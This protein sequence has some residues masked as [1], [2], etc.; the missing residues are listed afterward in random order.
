MHV[1]QNGLD[2]VESYVSKIRAVAVLDSMN[3]RVKVDVEGRVSVPDIPKTTLRCI[4]P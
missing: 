2:Q 1:G 3:G 4:K